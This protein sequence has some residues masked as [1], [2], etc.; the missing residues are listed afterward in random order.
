M[1]TNVAIQRP[2]VVF[3]GAGFGGLSA[4]KSLAKAPFEVATMTGSSA[5]A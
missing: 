1:P 5:V 3:V 2:R 4:A